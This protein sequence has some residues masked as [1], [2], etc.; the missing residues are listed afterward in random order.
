MAAVRLL[1]FNIWFAAH[2][3]RSRME[4]DAAAK[5]LNYVMMSSHSVSRRMWQAIAKIIDQKSPDLIALQDH[6]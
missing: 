5:I 3:M 4:A 1:T 6:P 2:E